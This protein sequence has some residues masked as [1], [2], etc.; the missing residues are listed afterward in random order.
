MA[1]LAL[2]ACWLGLA[3]AALVTQ[4]LIERKKAPFPPSPFHLLRWR[5]DLVKFST[6]NLP[7]LLSINFDWI[8]S[9]LQLQL[10]F[11]MERLLPWWRGRSQ[12]QAKSL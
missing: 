6:I 5:R 3:L 1:D 11:R 7:L 4:L 12:W 10:Q 9:D 8:P 2:L